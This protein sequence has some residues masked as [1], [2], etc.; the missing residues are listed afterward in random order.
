MNH[1][2]YL[3][4]INSEFEDDLSVDKPSY[5]KEV[6]AEMPQVKTVTEKAS[7]VERK[8]AEIHKTTYR[9]ILIGKDDF[10]IVVD[11]DG[12]TITD[13]ELL[14]ELRSL[15]FDIAE[16]EKIAPYKVLNNQGLVSLAT[17]RPETREDFISL[18]GLGETKYNAYG[19]K[20]IESI[21]KFYAKK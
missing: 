18:Y 10:N 21:K 17:Y 19:M 14:T 5:Q 3:R 20:F 12:N 4:W 15:R 9:T 16:E 2:Y 11:D 1:E 13:M 6:V 7:S 8:K